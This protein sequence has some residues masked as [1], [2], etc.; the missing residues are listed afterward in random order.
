MDESETGVVTR[1]N[2]LESE[3]AFLEIIHHCRHDSYERVLGAY[4][5]L[6]TD[7]LCFDVV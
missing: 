3:V 4:D 1:A 6:K 5:F 2:E 7:W